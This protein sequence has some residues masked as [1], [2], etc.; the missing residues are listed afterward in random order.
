MDTNLD[1]RWMTD[2]LDALEPDWSADPGRARVVLGDRLAHEKMLP[3]TLSAPLI[4]VACL[5]VALL[6]PQTRS[7]A[8]EIWARWTVGRLAV[9]HV[10]LPTEGH[11]RMDGPI[12]QNVP[13]AEVAGLAGYEA[14]VP[15]DGGT[16][17]QPVISVL[18]RIQYSEIIRV[19]AIREALHR[20]GAADVTVPDAWDNLELRADIGPTV[21]AEYADGA[22]IAQTRPFPLYV[23]VGM[24]LTDIANAVFRSA[25]LSAAEAKAMALAY[26]IQPA[27][28]LDIGR[29]ERVGVEQVTLANGPA[30]VLEDLN[31][32]TGSSERITVLRSTADRLF[33]VVGPT[34]ERAFA[35][36]EAVK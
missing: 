4:A 11:V 32:S 8:Q 22:V 34:R 23:P 33:M 30:I 24:P 13:V 5:A 20:V 12:T 26:A 10:G 7:F 6:F 19:S 16:G 15:A 1:T 2:R 17:G 36:A 21:V 14:E 35:L 29:N 27:W 28:F 31:A 9:V 18:S 3:W 25:G